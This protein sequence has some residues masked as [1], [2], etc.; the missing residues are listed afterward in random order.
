MAAV[1]SFFWEVS[2]MVQAEMERGMA[3][4][5]RWTCR[6]EGS[7]WGDF[8]H[9]DEIGRLNLITPQKV[10]EGIAEVKV[11]KRFCLSLPLDYP[12]GSVVNP[13]R[14]PPVL[15]PNT[16]NGKPNFNYP[17]RLHN[18]KYT[19]IVCDDL[20]TISMQ[21]STHWDTF[22]H[23]G[24]PFDIDGDGVD[25]EVYYNG[26]RAHT[27]VVGPVIFGPSGELWPNDDE[28]KQGAR[29]L[30]VEKLAF[31]CIQGRAVMVDLEAHFGRTGKLVGYDD[32]R[33]ILDA[34]NVIVEPG[35]LVCFRTGF[36]RALLEMKKRP[37]PIVLANTTT[38]LDGRDKR[39]QNWITESG[40]VALISDNEGVERIPSPS[41]AV[42][43]QCCAMAPLHEHCLFRLG[44]L[45]G[46]Q[47]LLSDLADWLKRNG[48]SRFFLTAPPLRLPGAVG[49]PVTPIGLV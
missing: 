12:G 39:L 27:D 48:R 10:L 5:P 19:E 17:A 24:Y 40:V 7:N 43:D 20:A 32:L 26:F 35:D 49:S 46:E 11:G 42:V 3:G 28:G 6:P 23:A 36:D 37:D 22:A 31:S 1:C 41:G 16:W 8:G 47:W 30:G 29:H 44:V 9:D 18:P 38:A 14:S 2:K 45:L 25:E 4:V 15:R 13:R 34:D 21:Y 33:R